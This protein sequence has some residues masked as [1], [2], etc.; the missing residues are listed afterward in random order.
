MRWVDCSGSRA[1]Q[2]TASTCKLGAETLFLSGL[3]DC[4]DA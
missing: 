4:Y 1:A 2:N 3:K